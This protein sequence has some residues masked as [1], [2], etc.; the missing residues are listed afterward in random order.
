MSEH[1][2]L[3]LSDWTVVEDNCSMR[4]I[5]HT[6]P[7]D[8]RNRV[9]FIEKTPRIRVGAYRDSPFIDS[10]NWMY[11]DKS[12]YGDPASQVWCDDQLFILGWEVYDDSAVITRTQRAY[13]WLLEIAGY[14]RVEIDPDVITSIQR[15]R[16]PTWQALADALAEAVSYEDGKVYIIRTWS[17]AIRHNVLCQI[18][19]G[20]PV[21]WFAGRKNAWLVRIDLEGTKDF[22][23][24]NDT[25]VF[26]CREL[27]WMGRRH[28]THFH[29]D[30]DFAHGEEY[31][32]TVAGI[33]RTHAELT[34]FLN[35]A[36]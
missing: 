16:L 22:G 35:Q 33:V 17:G 10:I 15:D 29:P 18:K 6:D 23:D 31:R 1:K 9:A 26:M 21:F 7:N 5:R 20:K 11:G 30:F 3:V 2:S 12:Y 27:L 14:A 19:D 28:Q 24:S 13:F 4:Y 32:Q 34:A 36:K 8:I 25:R